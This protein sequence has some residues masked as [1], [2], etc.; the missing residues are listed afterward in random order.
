M[1]QD[2]RE[3][4]GLSRAAMGRRI[5]NNR[6]WWRTL[7]RG[8][9]SN[10]RP[11]LAPVLTYARACLAVGLTADEVDIR[12]ERPGLTEVE[13]ERLH[14]IAR[15]IQQLHALAEDLDTQ[16]RLPPKGMTVDDV[17]AH[18]ESLRD[19]CGHET[20][21]QALQRLGWT[22]PPGDSIEVHAS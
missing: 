11:F 21:R 22:S 18:L 14:L 13:R 17:C 16:L 8:L 6:V 10:G 12:A 7:E 19:L 5:G 2:R 9:R 3:A 1:L 4:L 15:G 20:L